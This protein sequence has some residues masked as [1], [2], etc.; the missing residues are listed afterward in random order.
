MG[1]DASL[2]IFNAEGASSY[3]SKVRKGSQK[4][5]RWFTTDYINIPITAARSVGFHS[6]TQRILTN[7]SAVQCLL[8][9]RRNLMDVRHARNGLGTEVNYTCT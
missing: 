2:K 9:V 4:K 3:Q 6:I 5:E 1:V 8:K 7:T